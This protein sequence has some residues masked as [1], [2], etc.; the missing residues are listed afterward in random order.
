MASMSKEYAR[1]VGVHWATTLLNQLL[2]QS[3]IVPFFRGILVL[4]S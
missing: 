4:R 2:A 3:R 1:F